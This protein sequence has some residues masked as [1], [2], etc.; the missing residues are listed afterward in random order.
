MKSI[1]IRIGDVSKRFRLP[2]RY[3]DKRMAEL[4]IREFIRK[5]RVEQGLR[6]IK[7]KKERPIELMIPLEHERCIY[8]VRESKL[9]SKKWINIFSKDKLLLLK[10]AYIRKLNTELPL[11]SN[12]PNYKYAVNNKLQ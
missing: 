9:F 1:E 11:H 2:A 8:W 4:A 7:E 12:H 6:K 5:V 3:Q 10:E